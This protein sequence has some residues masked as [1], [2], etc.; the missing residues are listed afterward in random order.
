MGVAASNIAQ[1]DYGDVSAGGIPVRAGLDIAGIPIGTDQYIRNALVDIIMNKVGVAYKA[2][3]T[4][5]RVQHRHLLNTFCCGTPQ[6]QHLWQSI[7][8]ALS[9][10]AIH[11]TD[12]MTYM[13][14][15]RTMGAGGELSPQAA[16]QTFLP[17]RFGGLGYKRS[18]DISNAAY[19][20]GFALAAYGPYS[21]A[22]QY[23][24]LAQDIFCPET[25]S[26]PSL[27]A[28]TQLWEEEVLLTPRAL[29]MATAAAARVVRPSQDDLESEDDPALWPGILQAQ[30]TSYEIR[31]KSEFVE[32]NT[33]HES[34]TT[35]AM[36]A[37]VLERAH[38]NV[39]T[40]LATGN[41]TPADQFRYINPSKCPSILRLWALQGGGHFQKNSPAHVTRG[42][43]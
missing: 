23:P 7:L 33:L 41:W 1:Q 27:I 39:V 35:A 36:N 15:K 10:D 38:S 43:F 9:V 28:L 5:T 8:P 19:I 21:I 13:A 17:Q 6:A 42:G 11:V 12:G 34:R 14:A 32:G 24:T 31:F 3:D 25:S 30:E 26:L 20:G 29:A 37:L 16:Y 2:V 22:T 4:L 40:L 18:R